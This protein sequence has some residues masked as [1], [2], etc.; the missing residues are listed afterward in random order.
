MCYTWRGTLAYT[1]NLKNHVKIVVPPW[2][3]TFFLMD[4]ILYQIFKTILS[5]SLKKHEKLTDNPP[6]RIYVNK[7]ENSKLHSKLKEDIISNFYFLKQ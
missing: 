3:E 4:C 1:K 7:I 6:I 5:I 2:N